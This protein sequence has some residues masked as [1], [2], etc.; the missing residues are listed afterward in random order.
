MKD[1]YFG[2]INDYRKCELN[3][4]LQAETGRKVL[5]T[6]ILTPDDGWRG[7]EL[8]RLSTQPD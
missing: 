8:E 2:D 7:G 4:V 3:R 1:H 6:W 5:M